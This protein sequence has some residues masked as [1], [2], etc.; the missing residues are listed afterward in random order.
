MRPPGPFPL[1]GYITWQDR[2]AGA[3]LD[4]IEVRALC[5][6]D[7]HR[8][9]AVCVL[10]LLAVTQDLADRIVAGLGAGWRADQV[11]VAATHTHS[12]PGGYWPTRAARFFMGRMR[13]EVRD[14][15]V[16][17]A[18]R[19]VAEA[20]VDLRPAR[21][22]AGRAE[23]RGLT[24]NRCLPCGPTDDE[25]VAL[26]LDRPDG[27]LVLIEIAGHPVVV[28]EHDQAAVSADWPGAVRRRL[29]ARGLRPVVL[30]GALA[31]LS[32]IFPE[33]PTALDRHLDLVAGLATDATLR[34][35][36]SAT[37][38]A[39]STVGA[40]VERV[41]LGPPRVRIYPATRPFAH[42]ASWP[43]RQL[44]AG[45]LRAA[46]EPGNAS[47]PVHALRVG[48]FALLGFPCDLGVEVAL[49]ARAAAA[50]AGY[51]PVAVASQVGG[52]AG[53]VHHAEA[54]AGT[55]APSQRGLWTYENAMGFFG[56]GLAGRL[57]AAAAR[58][59]ARAAG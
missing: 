31:G 19:A 44:M 28:A 35:L 51:G 6:D 48:P 16:S 17:A 32:V 2:M 11:L 36:D 15:L 8:R 34:A 53:Y 38:L 58:A 59:L 37:P 13:P 5:L 50:A 33:F 46:S 9:V 21:A 4:D 1:A 23:A 18:V 57:E 49:Q 45:Y 27:A 42:L 10:D 7:G 20:A 43:L 14:H 55:P 47:A 29:E 3:S 52:Y 12:G 39:R 25:V 40:A 41:S 56:T 30:T 22:S 26:R 54:A 24:S